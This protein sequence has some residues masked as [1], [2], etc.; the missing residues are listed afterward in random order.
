VTPSPWSSGAQAGWSGLIPA[1]GSHDQPPYPFTG[2]LLIALVTF[3]LPA[4]GSATDID[5]RVMPDRGL[6][7][8][9]VTS[10]VRGWWCSAKRGSD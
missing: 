8:I 7:A 1:G 9:N 2:T 4:A 10:G 5:Y 3:V 6:I